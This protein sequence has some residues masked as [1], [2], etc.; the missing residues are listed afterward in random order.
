MLNWT[1]REMLL[2][3]QQLLASVAAVAG[4]FLLVLFFEGVF[5]GESEQIVALIDKTDADVWVMQ[6]GVGNMHMTTSFVADWKVDAVAGVEGVA[7]A[8]PILYMNS[9]IEAGGRSWFSYVVGVEAGDPRVGPWA[10]AEGAAHPATGGAVV[11]DIFASDAGLKPGDSLRIGG[12]DFRVDGFSRDTFSM[13]NSIAFVSFDDLADVMESLGVV[14]Y[15]LVDA[16][17]GIDPQ[18]LVER[19]KAEVEAVNALPRA[20]FVARDY[21]IAV[22]MGLNIIWI[23]TLIGGALAVLLTGFVVYSHVTERERDLAVMKALG[24]R[25]RA[26]YAAVCAQALSIGGLAFALALALMA[27]AVPLTAALAPEISVAITGAS[28]LRAGVTALVVSLVAAVIPVRRVV[29]VD[30]VTAFQQ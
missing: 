4:A 12:R 24:V 13:A 19:I 6:K 18:A 16:E 1:F 3:P 14:S 5:A 15:I 22:Q 25:D 7:K 30:P 9:A 2:A 27:A 29:S 26:I 23:M 8:T 20:V 11:P 10:M 17:P 21:S 28:V